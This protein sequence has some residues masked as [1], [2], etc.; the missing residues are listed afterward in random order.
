MSW[1][2]AGKLGISTKSSTKSRT[3]N[4]LNMLKID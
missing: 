2:G 3:N 1:T 4:K